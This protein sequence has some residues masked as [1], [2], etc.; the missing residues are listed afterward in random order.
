MTHCEHDPLEARYANSFKVGHNAS[1]FLLDFGQCF[2]ATNEDQ[3]HSRIIVS[4]DHFRDLCEL[5]GEALAQ[6]ERAFGA[7]RQGKFRPASERKQDGGI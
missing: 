1:E 3:F 7:R 4:P 5:L 6:Y 2:E